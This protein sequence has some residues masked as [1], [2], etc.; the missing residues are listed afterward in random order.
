MNRCLGCN[1]FARRRLTMYNCTIHLQRLYNMIQRNYKSF[2]L[3]LASL[4]D[5]TTLLS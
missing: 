1:S 5:E 2:F 3:D 4:A